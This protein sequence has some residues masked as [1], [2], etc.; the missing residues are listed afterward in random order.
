MEKKLIE[1]STQAILVAGMHRSGTSALT[2]TLSILGAD[3]PRNLMPPMK[4][5]NDKGFW[6]SKDLEG[7]HDSLL[8]SAGSMWDDWSEFNPEWFETVTAIQYKKKIT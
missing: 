7:I 4:G 1:H 2:K 3:L 6:E 5:N 8:E